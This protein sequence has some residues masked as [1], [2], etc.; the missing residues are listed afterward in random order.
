MPTLALLAAA[1]L[2]AAPRPAAASEPDALR[3]AADAYRAVSAIAAGE[4]T[5]AEVQAAAA[6][7]AGA[8]PS[9]SYVAR[10]RLAALLPRLTAEVR[11]DERTQRIVG[12][13]GAGEVDYQRLSPGTV[14]ALRATWDL[15][16]LVAARGELAGESAAAL[17]ARRREEAVRR[18]TALFYERR[19]LRLEL[20]LAPPE[21]ALV[22]ARAEL[23]V[24][25]LGAEL[26]ALTGG[27]FTRG[28]R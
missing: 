22:R 28:L 4:P 5:I 19:K 8:A 21:D 16:D 13:Q 24:E 10:A 27:M 1:T 7:R 12:L 2:A 25:R 3:T 11:R 9:D 6:R 15:G 17:R 26:D 20:W 14:V 18:A 23:E